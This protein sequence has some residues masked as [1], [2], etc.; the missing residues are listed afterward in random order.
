[1]TIERVSLRTS[2]SAA[3]VPT[4]ELLAADEVCALLH[5][6]PAIAAGSVAVVLWRVGGAVRLTR[7]GPDLPPAVGLRAW[8]TACHGAPGRIARI[9]A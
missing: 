3:R 8:V 1:M 9:G 2:A 5:P 7:Y 4:G 6:Q